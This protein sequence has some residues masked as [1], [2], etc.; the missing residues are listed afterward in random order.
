VRIRRLAVSAKLRPN[1]ES[2]RSGCRAGVITPK[3]LALVLLLA[4]AGFDFAVAPIARVIYSRP[5]NEACCDQT[6]RTRTA[7]D[8]RSE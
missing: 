5:I 3:S 7:R 8:E 1:R 6:R 4:T 2:V